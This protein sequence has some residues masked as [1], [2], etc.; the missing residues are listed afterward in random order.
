MLTYFSRS[1]REESP[2]LDTIDDLEEDEEP[3]VIDQEQW[4]GLYSTTKFIYYQ[5]PSHNMN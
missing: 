4:Q 2:E 5:R 3:L 1:V